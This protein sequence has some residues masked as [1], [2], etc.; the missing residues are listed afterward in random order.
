MWNWPWELRRHLM[1]HF[2]PQ[3][4]NTENSYRCPEPGCG[5][6]FQWKR[7]MKQHEKIHTGD[8]LLVCSVCQKKFTTRQALLHHVVVHTG[9]KPFQC[10]VC[11]NRFTQPAN[12]RTHTKKKHADGPI[13]GSK[14]PH[15]QETFP[16][17]VAIHQHILEDH[18][19]IVAEQREER[20][21]E[22]LRKEQD[23]NEKEARKREALKL[24]EEKR[25]ERLDAHDFRDPRSD[26]SLNPN[27]V[28]FSLSRISVK[29]AFY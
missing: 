23:K 27:S 20:H 25:R 16:S 26:H 19:N 13:R 6:K 9:E 22:K 1:I 28:G 8:K 2:K 29:S 7:D 12:L 21:M 15:C 14:C 18:Q 4:L 11:G 10:A 3:K 17:L 24:K 5:K